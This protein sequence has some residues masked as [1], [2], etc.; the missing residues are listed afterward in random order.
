VPYVYIIESF[1]LQLSLVTQGI[2]GVFTEDAKISLSLCLSTILWKR[3][4]KCK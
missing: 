2:F 3:K 1:V 4:G